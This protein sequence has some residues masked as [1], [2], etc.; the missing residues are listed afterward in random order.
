MR[1][2]TGALPLALSRAK[3]ALDLFSNSQ[4]SALVN[5]VSIAN[6]L[7]NAQL[8]SVYTFSVTARLRDQS[9]YFHVSPEAAL[10]V[11]L[12]HAQMLVPVA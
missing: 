6:D 7:V 9:A 1:I 4:T 2:A 11:P 12:Q 10:A 8:L 5:N 3:D